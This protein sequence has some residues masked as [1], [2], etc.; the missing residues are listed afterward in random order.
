MFS[1]FPMEANRATAIG[2][3]VSSKVNGALRGSKVTLIQ[4]EKRRREEKS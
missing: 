3:M 2:R 4:E 1:I